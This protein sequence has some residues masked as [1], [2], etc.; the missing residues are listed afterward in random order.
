MSRATVLLFTLLASL[1]VFG[2]CNPA[3]TLTVDRPF[4][5]EPEPTVVAAQASSGC[6]ITAISVYVDYKLIYQQ[7]GQNTLSGRLVMGNGP[8]RV[9]IVA[10]NSAGAS[11]KDVRYIVTNADP[12]E[13]PAGCDISDAI[14]YTGDHI[15]FTTKSPARAWLRTATL[16][17]FLP[18]VFI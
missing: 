3:I 6:R 18:F 15:P 2:A 8:H 4:D 14:Q 9:A 16:L 5:V 12:V 13:P 7:H 10:H 11:M 1:P 17:Q